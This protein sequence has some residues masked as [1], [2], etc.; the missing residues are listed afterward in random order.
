MKEK[1]KKNIDN[2]MNKIFDEKELKQLKMKELR[3]LT[4]DSKIKALYKLQKTNIIYA[5]MRPTDSNVQEGDSKGNEFH[6][7]DR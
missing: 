4:Q 1:L 2:A 7:L 5:L 3:K 6:F